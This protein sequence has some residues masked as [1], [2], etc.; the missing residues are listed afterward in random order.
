MSSNQKGKKKKKK[1][2]T[3]VQRW[4]LQG[5]KSDEKHATHPMDRTANWSARECWS[6]EKTCISARTH[7]R[8]CLLN[9][10]LVEYRCRQP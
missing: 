6:E 3:V 7:Y 4:L 1:R 5:E 9:E 8:I 10:I 2:L